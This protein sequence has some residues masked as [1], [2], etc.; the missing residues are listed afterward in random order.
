MSIDSAR[1]V[2]TGCDYETREVYRPIRIRYQ[3]TKG[4][5]V[6]TGRAKGWCY[7]C[8]SY[9]DIEIMNQGEL[10]DELISKERERLEAHHRH[11]ELNRGFL[12]NFRHR[13]EKRELQ[14]QFEWLDKEIDKLGGLLEIAKNR[15]SKA[16]CLKCW[17]DRTAPLTFNSDSNIACD[18]Q[19]ECGGNL[20][21]IHDHSG[22]R[23]NFR[24][25]T[26]LL[27]EEGE[28]LGEE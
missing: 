17:S 15:K 2:C 12:S 1:I 16:R 10:H 28:L 3:T 6:E 22:P 25:S 24:V 27:N 20:Q 13:S 26:Y 4:R 9:S 5:T 19:H 21:I 11:D 14:H 7:D 23:F 18:F 8:A